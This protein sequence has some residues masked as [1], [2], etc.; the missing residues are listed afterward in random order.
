MGPKSRVYNYDIKNIN[1]IHIKFCK[2]I[3]G[4]RQQTPNSAVYGEL[5]RYPLSVICKERELNFLIRILKLKD[6]DSLVFRVYQ[7]MFNQM[8]TPQTKSWAL[9][10]KTELNSLGLSNLWTRQF[11]IVPQFSVIKQRIRDQDIQQRNAS[12]SSM[13][14][15]YLFCCFF[16]SV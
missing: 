13:Y 12:L 2:S 8:D 10:I 16:F 14:R 7:Y 15:G 1:R 11:E 4:L 9:A 6:T 3:L 5:G